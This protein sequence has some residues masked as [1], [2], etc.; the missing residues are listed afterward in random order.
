MPKFYFTY[1]TEGQPFVGG[2]TEVEAENVQMAC[3]A[4]R[5]VH[6]DRYHNCLNCCGFYTEEQFKNSCMSGPEGN[7]HKFCH[8]R[9][10][11]TCTPTDPDEYPGALA[12]VEKKG[13]N[14]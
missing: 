2:W 14:S 4:F 6:P 10:V 11:I 5:A 3:G 7:F 1:G 12:P 8:E 9:I 13:D